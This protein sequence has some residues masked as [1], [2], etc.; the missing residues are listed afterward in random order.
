M[1][2]SCTLSKQLQ[3]LAHPV[4][5]DIVT[6]LAKEG[7][8]MYL[9][10][11]SNR[12][13]I[14]RALAKIHLNKLERANIVKSRRVPLEEEERALRYYKLLNFSIHLSPEIL[15]EGCSE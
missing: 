4:R 11:I 15:K 8:E 13:Q 12:L 9:N 10:Q 3:G 5:L 7:K 6:L 1:V 14:N 2:S